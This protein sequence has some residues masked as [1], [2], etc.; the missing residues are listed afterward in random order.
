MGEQD[1]TKRRGQAR[2]DKTKGTS[3]TRQDKMPGASKTRLEASV[4]RKDAGGE[5]D[6]T[7]RPTQIRLQVFAAASQYTTA[8]HSLTQSHKHPTLH[9]FY[10]IKSIFNCSVQA[11][12][13]HSCLRVGFFPGEQLPECSLASLPNVRNK[14]SDFTSIGRSYAVGN[15]R[16]E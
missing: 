1:K 9:L 10:L 16:F 12:T 5:R 2:Q 4:T 13:Q 11:S 8:S 7:R 6:G 15:R 3:E 14:H